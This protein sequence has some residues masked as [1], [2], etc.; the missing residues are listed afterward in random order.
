MGQLC[1]RP[2]GGIVEC[3][4]ALLIA[5]HRSRRDAEFRQGMSQ[6]LREVVV[7]MVPKSVEPTGFRT[8]L[9]E[10]QQVRGNRPLWPVLLGAMLDA[11][12]QR[13]R[14]LKVG[15]SGEVFIDRDSHPLED[16]EREERQVA[17]LFRAAHA[18]DGCLTL[19]SE[20]IWLLGYQ[21]PTQGGSAEKGRRADLIG[22]TADGGLVVLEAKLASGTAPLTAILEGLD[23]LA[24]LHRQPNFDK[25]LRGFA[26]WKMKPARKI[27]AG[28]EQTLLSRDARP[29]LVVLAPESY[30]LGRNA[31]SIRGKE[32][33]F[34]ASI[35]DALIPSV[36]VVLGEN[37]FQSI[38]VT[39]M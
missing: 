26:R 25:I 15:Y 32:W 27:P 18:G 33:P 24:C 13:Q 29:L 6:S 17:R 10:L 37:D 16:G 7:E 30:Y 21:W 22:I 38:D 12:F 19:G 2:T 36:R 3:D 23:Y 35:G 11:E 9:L 28:F 1:H 34:V 5:R 39:R 8:W 4:V 20:K 14:E 31:R